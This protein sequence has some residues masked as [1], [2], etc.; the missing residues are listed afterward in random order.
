MTRSR[1][2]LV[3]IG[4]VLSASIAAA[5]R[6]GGAA[7]ETPPPP[8]RVAAPIDLT[9]YWVSV[10]TEDW[11]WRMVTPAKG[12]Y[13]SVPINAEAKKV[14][15][16]WDP[17]R[18]EKA[19]E[20]CKAYGAPGVMRQPTRLHITW[21]DDNTLKVET[22]AGEQTRL[23]H[24]GDWKSPG[25]RATWQG[26]TTARWETPQGRRAQGAPT[27]GPRPAPEGRGAGSAAPEPPKFGNL[28]TVTTRLRPGYLRKNGLPYSEKATLT[29]YWDLLKQKNGD[30]WLVIST[31]VDD[32][33]YLNTPWITSLN[34]KKERDGSKWDPAP[35]SAR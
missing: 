6:Q 5:Q 32:P 19:G 7:P 8:P 25:G 2:F 10:I 34:F 33:T 27:F 3:A 16:T 35:C 28:K 31:T 14:G 23:F 9:G 21:Q 30:Q 13:A 4:A 29:E 11:R 15:D 12:D 26:D 1:F 22:D 24:F 18:D 20:A 17:A